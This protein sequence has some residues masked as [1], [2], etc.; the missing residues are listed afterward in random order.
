MFFFNDM[1]R[2]PQE[3]MNTR[4][5]N[6]Q[7]DFEQDGIYQSLFE[8]SPVSI[9]LQ[10]FSEVKDYLER[11]MRHTVLTAG[12]YLDE[13]PQ[14]VR[15]CAKMVRIVD[16]NKVGLAMY[17]ALDRKD[18]AGNLDRRI[19]MSNLYGWRLSMRA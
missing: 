13:N 14:E 16:V 11:I 3:H 2:K 9:W 17:G 15:L 7:V 8:N 6:K 12:E 10:D 18:L 4:Q 5:K 1:L 19:K